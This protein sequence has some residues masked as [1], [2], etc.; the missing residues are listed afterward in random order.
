M[1]IHSLHFSLLWQSLIIIRRVCVCFLWQPPHLMV[2]SVSLIWITSFDW[3]S[4]TSGIRLQ[5]YFTVI[6]HPWL[7][8]TMYC[9]YNGWWKYSTI[10][11]NK[12][13]I[14]HSIVLFNTTSHSCFILIHSCLR[15]SHLPMYPDYSNFISYASVCIEIK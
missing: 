2:V 14:Y 7:Q 8:S 11:E 12:V 13:C 1:R 9:T 4:S 6:T 15:F 10:L 5:T 3:T